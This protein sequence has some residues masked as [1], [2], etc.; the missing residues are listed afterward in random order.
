MSTNA[1]LYVQVFSAGPQAKA[2]LLE[3]QQF[4]ALDIANLVEE[5]A[6]M[7]KS[8]QNALERRLE[9]LVRHLLKWQYQPEKRVLGHSWQLTILEQRRR[10]GRL[11]HQSPSL[12][13]TL[14]AV[15]AESYAYVRRRT[16][17]ETSL[18]LAT[19][20]ESCPWTP[21][22]VLDADFWPED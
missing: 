16:S 7:G 5:I 9:V 15:L 8:Q 11:L 6:S 12:R 19:F 1:E 14:P 22:Q 10:L 2:A 17:L 20:P 21:E 18:P 3:A 13:P 4:D